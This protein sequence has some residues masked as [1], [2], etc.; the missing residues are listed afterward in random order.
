MAHQAGAIAIVDAAQA[1]LQDQIDVQNWN[2]DFVCFS[3]HKLFGP[4]GFGILYGKLELL[5]QMPP[6]K[7]GGAM[8]TSVHFEKSEFQKSP[9]RFE[10]GTPHIEGAIGLHAAIKYLEQ[11]DWAQ[12]HDYKAKLRSKVESE[13][14]QIEGLRIFGHPQNKATVF[15]F[16]IDGLHSSDVGQILDQQGIAVRV[17]HHCTQPLMRLLG[18]EGTVRASFSIYNNDEDI[19]KFV[20]GLKKAQELLT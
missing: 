19:E 3:A 11:F 2:A 14:S 12:I 20:L 6:Y 16:V 1:V 5:N 7:T 10:A 8:I 15:S 4:T 13:L 18:V 9:M 17:G